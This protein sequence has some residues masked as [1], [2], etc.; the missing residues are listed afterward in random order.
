MR[1]DLYLF[2]LLYLPSFFPRKFSQDHIDA[3]RIMQ[4][5]ILHG[6]R[7]ALAMPRGHGKSTLVKAL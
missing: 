2:M 1:F 7:F 6:G 5:A 4:D 3:I